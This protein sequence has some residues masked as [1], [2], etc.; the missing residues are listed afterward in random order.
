MIRIYKKI[1]V[2][3][4]QSLENYFSTGGFFLSEQQKTSLQGNSKLMMC[5]RLI[6]GF[7]FYGF[8]S[9]DADSFVLMRRKPWITSL[10]GFVLEIED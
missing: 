8:I 7:W 9:I 6:D 1:E 5:N 10:I 3:T 4:S 2:K